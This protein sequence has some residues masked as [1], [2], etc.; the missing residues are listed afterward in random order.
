[1]SFCHQKHAQY[2]LQLAKATDS[3]QALV[4][5]QLRASSVYWG[6]TSLFLLGNEDYL[7]GSE[8]D[9][10]KESLLH[11]V[12]SCYCPSSGG[13]GGNVG[14]DPHILYTLSALQVLALI[15][16]LSD[17]SETQVDA[18]SSY[19]LSLQQ[20][21]GSFFGD[22]WG[23]VDS[24]FTYCAVSILSLLNRLHLLDKELTISFL[25][26]CR[27]NDGGF[28][29]GPDAESH[30]G[31]VFCVVGTL[32]ILHSLNVLST[33]QQDT[34]C[35]WLAER[36]DHTG[37][38]CGR[39]MKKSDV[40]YSWWV[41]SALSVMNRINWLNSSKLV[42]F[43]LSCQDEDDGGIS[44]RP[45][46]VAD[47]FHTFFGIAGLSLLDF[48]GIQADKIDATYALPVSVVN[49]LKLSFQR[50]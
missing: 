43:I 8:H 15:D 21:D 46:N 18:I 41:I 12:M 32:S 1:M 24:R 30:A 17:L 47:M 2:I 10:G 38:L 27:N 49:S 42:D 14:H 31:Q 34:L 6:L 4:T 39:P 5:E 16:S 19:V 13:F 3:L 29:S 7:L 22:T 37:G 40:C 48:P 44:D 35:W 9:I 50:L 33:S 45:G 20:S 11:F 36:Q 23:E 28:G 26:K 25:L